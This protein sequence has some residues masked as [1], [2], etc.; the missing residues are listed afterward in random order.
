MS[1]M[2]H[3][4]FFVIC[5]NLQP[6]SWNKLCEGPFYSEDAITAS[7]VMRKIFEILNIIVKAIRMLNPASIYG[8]L[9]VTE[10]FVV[11]GFTS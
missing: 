3:D 8:L 6:N 9:Q 4:M 11:K 2:R 5:L 1:A 10:Y 7:K